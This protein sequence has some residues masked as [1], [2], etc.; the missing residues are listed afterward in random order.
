MKYILNHLGSNNFENLVQSLS[1]EIFGNGSIAFG[2]GSDGGRDATFHGKATYPS[3]EE[4]WDG[5]WVIQA[6]FKEITEA[7][8]TK[9]FE[10]VKDE[11]TKEL[12]KYSTRK[13]KVDY[14]DNYILFTNVILTAVAKVGGRDKATLLEKEYQ[15]KY[16]IKNIRIISYDDICTHLNRYRNI[17]TTY[18]A[19]VLPGDIL[20][21][22]LEMLQYQ[23]DKQ[24]RVTEVVGRFLEAEFKEDIQ[25]K[26]EHAGKLTTDKVNLEKVF[27]D[28]YVEKENA[29][30][31]ASQSKFIHKAITIGNSILKDKPDNYRRLV[32]EAGPGQGKSTLTQFLCQIYRA[33]FLKN[34]DD[35]A[36]LSDQITEFIEE[37]KQII[38][39]E[40]LWIRLPIRIII[41][42]YASW[43][44]KEKKGNSEANVGVLE[45]I[46]A[47]I[48]KKSKTNEIEAVDVEN[49]IRNLPCLFIFDGLDEVP[50]TSNREE[51]INEIFFFTDTFLR[52]IN[53]DYIIVATTRP[54]GYS[55]EFDVVKYQHFFI[56][57]LESE[58]SKLYVQKLLDK[59]I[60]NVDE[61]EEKKE[62][63]FKVIE[64]PEMSR[65]M[66]SPLQ[67]SI[68]TILVL[69]GGNPPENKFELFTEYYNTI[70]KREKQRSVSPILNEKQSYITEIHEK[71]G[72]FLQAE[73]E[74]SVNPGASIKK[75]KFAKLVEVYL[76]NKGLE[77]DQITKMA[78]EILRVATDR[79]VF[80]SEIED[81]QIGFAIRSL[82]EYFAATDLI[83][84]IE[85]QQIKPRLVKI[86]C[87][88]YWGNTL[89]FAIG[90]ISKNK[91]YL[92]STIESICNE[93]NG[94]SNEFEINDLNSKTK[95]GSWLAL[96]ILNEGIFNDTPNDENKFGN[97][98]N[99]LF[100]I[101]LCEKH[102]LLSKLPERLIKKWIS[103]NLRKEL[104]IN[105]NNITCW[106]ICFDL[107]SKGYNLMDEMEAYW[108]DDSE[109]KKSLIIL[110]SRKN[111]ECDQFVRKSLDLVTADHKDF[112]WELLDHEMHYTYFHLIAVN[113]NLTEAN[114]KIIV[115]LLFHWL[116][117][118]NN[119]LEK[120]LK[121]Y[122]HLGFSLDDLANSPDFEF[123]DFIR[124]LIPMISIH[125]VN[126]YR[127]SLFS[128]KIQL[129][130]ELNHLINYGKSE[131]IDLI[132]TI[133][134]FY[135]DP[136]HSNY[137]KL[138]KY[139]RS[140]DAKYGNIIKTTLS[141]LSSIFFDIYS[142]LT[143]D[144]STYET[145]RDLIENIIS[146]GIQ[147]Q[148]NI[149]KYKKYSSTLTLS[150]T[151]IVQ[152]L[153]SLQELYELSST[154]SIEYI[155]SMYLIT[156][157]AIDH[158]KEEELVIIK[159]KTLD[160]KSF[161]LYAF[162][163]AL[164]N[165]V[166]I[167][168]NYYISMF[169]FLEA[170]EI[171]AIEKKYKLSERFQF[172]NLTYQE[173][174]APHVFDTV[175]NKVC[176]TIK[177]ALVND[178]FIP[179]KIILQALTHYLGIYMLFNP[180]EFQFE[181]IL[182][183][184]VKD[185]DEKYKIPILMQDQRFGE[186][187]LQEIKRM[188]IDH[189][190]AKDKELLIAC[191]NATKTLPTNQFCDNLLVFF[192]ETIEDSNEEIK[193]IFYDLAYAYVGRK[194][195]KISDEVFSF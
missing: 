30:V 56:S 59:L 136:T 68:M 51:V 175:Y 152:K 109:T 93:L 36:I 60:S 86:A 191:I 63:L 99:P 77:H 33:Y 27:I 181:E 42:D 148:D 111:V 162:T 174:S 184:R 100:K 96:E 134:D 57:N 94:S 179:Y 31:G 71:L 106:S 128:S 141:G 79:L 170:K 155:T 126:D 140:E 163:V 43:I 192:S 15:K 26:L 23:K 161:Y 20:F 61:Q 132:I 2:S 160:K 19:F 18:A 89:L 107:I 40:P 125:I 32:I 180:P 22:L 159:N 85:D 120:H 11:L 186:D 131:G 108:P 1:K 84:N 119:E 117:Q 3:P 24:H 129:P 14:P 54:Q 121:I 25:S 153:N 75:D 147:S 105:K 135:S 183:H 124:E 10:W 116:F 39:T 110:F 65:L 130:F 7:D 177:Y 103:T 156:D 112:L 158:F 12:N 122:K 189:N 8:D 9:D 62:I 52:R 44:K 149:M 145:N 16:K 187:H 64:H 81:E 190:I 78:K 70:L 142:N 72:L 91:K 169:Y 113:N 114:K 88:S 133:H 82:Q 193:T 137:S 29:V 45:Y 167:Y 83:H 67:V 171:I 46:K 74:K 146:N 172:Y 176:H 194:P 138:L 123:E 5:Y 115:E 150:M 185:I 69:S 151:D 58:E 98:L 90:Y 73:S 139:V 195:S 53:S 165:K 50:T 95:K 87:N 76:K 157:W 102:E 104:E 182:K 80:I 47:T 92:V 35:R 118:R 41:K 144:K 173:R 13:T 168:F 37:Y 66:K 154:K 101:P 38:S 6:K 127:Y 34:I 4:L 166:R 21:Q 188:F 143:C 97:L 17:A 164:Q 49:L 55:K 48:N 178:E 28:L